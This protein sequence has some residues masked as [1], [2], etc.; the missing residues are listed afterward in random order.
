MPDDDPYLS[1]SYYSLKFN[2]NSL[3]YIFIL[4][5][6]YIIAPKYNTI[7]YIEKTSFKTVL[8]IMINK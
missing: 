7:L 1:K 4:K 2:I 8:E 5:I 6:I 3:S